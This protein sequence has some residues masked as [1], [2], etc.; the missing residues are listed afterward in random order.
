MEELRIIL[1][2]DSVWPIVREFSGFQKAFL[3]AKLSEVI[4]IRNVV[5]HNR[6]TTS[7]T[8]AVWRGIATALRPGLDAFKGSLLYRT[9]DDV[10]LGTERAGSPVVALYSEHCQ[11]N[12]WCGTFSRCFQ[13]RST[14]TH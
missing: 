7:D 11:N 5:G 10:H 2:M 8:V 3:E 1:T 13:S 4:E 6:A 9:G 14:F 12:D